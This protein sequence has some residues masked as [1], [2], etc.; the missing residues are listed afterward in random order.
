MAHA[1]YDC[2]AVCDSKMAF[3]CDPETKG[4]ICSHCVAALARQGV[5]IPDVDALIDYITRTPAEELSRIL[6][7]VGF[8]Y[9][10]YS[11]RVDDAVR[12]KLGGEA[13]EEQ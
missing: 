5:I 10:Y 7:A 6:A 8:R 1:D 11:N 2:C 13:R 3:S 12:A 4:D 9:C